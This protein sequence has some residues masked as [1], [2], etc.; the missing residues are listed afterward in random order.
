[1]SLISTPS[2][3]I[4]RHYG[5]T[6]ASYDS[7]ILTLDAA[8]E[9]AA[10][11]VRAPATGT[12]K[13]V[14]FRPGSI[15][16]L[17]TLRVSFQDVSV[18]TGDPD[19]L[20]AQYRQV[21]VSAGDSGVGKETGLI[22]SDGTDGGTLRTVNRGDLLA[23]VFEHDPFNPGDLFRLSL[24][25]TGGAD[26][27]GN[28][29]CDHFTTAWSKKFYAPC[30]A[31]IYDEAGNDTCHPLVNAVPVMGYTAYTWNSAS[32]NPK[33]GLKFKLPFRFRLHGVQARL[34]FPSANAACDI[35]LYDSDGQTVL[36]SCTLPGNVGDPA[37]QRY[38]WAPFPTPAELQAD[39]FYYVLVEPTT[40]VNM[41]L[42]F[43][44]VP[45]GREYYWR[46]MDGG[47]D[48]HY[49][50]GSSG[51]PA[52]TPTRRPQICLEIEAVDDGTG[53]MRPGP[54]GMI[55]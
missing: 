12:L 5:L 14:G 8:G 28:G 19:G 25:S 55:R 17:Q 38:Y 39:T 29:Y 54:W 37:Y 10:F 13:K 47:L 26:C 20:V 22:T 35:K 46:Q 32:A 52:A 4:P 51:A 2:L 49:A 9:K 48:F 42:F 6:S 30:L 11:I 41:M 45:S 16:V 21:T 1:M 33:R 44:E 24:M 18:D 34:R 53:V 31:L 7:N 27:E 23:V 3:W 15:S 50:E 36:R 43:W 40:T